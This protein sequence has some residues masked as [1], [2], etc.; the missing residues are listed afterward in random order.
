MGVKFITGSSLCRPWAR[1]IPRSQGRHRLTVFALFVMALGMTGAVASVELRDGELREVCAG[2]GDK[3]TIL[4]VNGIDTDGDKAIAGATELAERLGRKYRVCLIFNDCT[5]LAIDFVALAATKL[6]DFDVELNPAA[7]TLYDAVLTHVRQGDRVVLVGHSLGGAIIHN[8]VN[9]L[10][11]EHVDLSQVSVILAGASV[12]EDDHSLSDGW[13]TGLAGRFS[14]SD[15]RDPVAQWFG[16]VEHND[17]YGDSENKWHAWSNYVRH[18]S[19]ERFEHLGSLVVRDDTVLVESV[20]NAAGAD[21][22]V[23]RVRIEA[24]PDQESRRSFNF[25]V[26][27]AWKRVRWNIEG[28]PDP[29]GVTFMP[30]YDEVAWFDEPAYEQQLRSGVVV[31]NLRPDYIGR[32]HGLDRPFFVTITPTTE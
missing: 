11:Q 6:G 31:A 10:A 12:F 32:V 30:M 5:N 9:A 14:I 4:F 8:V 16:D 22:R 7:D 28:H 13:P 1:R 17:F 24:M 19:D 23:I 3:L 18:I 29:S 2:G 20:H 26:P 27:G 21:K 25:R 15:A